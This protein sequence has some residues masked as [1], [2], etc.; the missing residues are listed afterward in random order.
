MIDVTIYF[1]IYDAI[2]CKEADTRL[3]VFVYVADV[4]QEEYRS[5]NGALWATRCN[6]CDVRQGFIN[7]DPL[8]T[9]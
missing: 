3:N 1:A 6:I 7:R 5:Q 4:Q 2:I 9:I 8:L